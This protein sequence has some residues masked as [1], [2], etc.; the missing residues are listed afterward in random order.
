MTRGKKL[1]IM[2]ADS[3]VLFRRCL[4]ALLSAESDMEV[5]GE[6]SDVA[7]TLAMARLLVPDA[8]VMNLSLAAASQA[9]NR[10]ALRQVS[11][12]SA[13]LFL[14]EEDTNEN[15]ELAIEAGARGYMLRNSTPGQL[16]AGI[17]QAALSDD[18]NPR[19]LSRLAP[20][21]KALASSNDYQKASVLTCANRK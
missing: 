5:V 10:L 11:T 15:F 6:S 16:V 9:D 2:L 8:V 3:H 18:Q 13:I 19:G 7:E 4:K 14:T 1:R 17:R 21:L 12:S 20:D